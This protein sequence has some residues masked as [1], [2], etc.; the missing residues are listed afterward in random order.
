MTATFRFAPSPNGRLHLG[1]ALSALLNQDMA[2]ALGGRV[3]LRI[4]DIDTARCTPELVTAMLEDLD[5]IG[6]AAEPP[7]RR[8]SEHFADYD[9]ALTR[10][11]SM[12]LVYDAFLTRTEIRQ[13]VALREASGTPWPRDPDGAPLYPGDAALLT[14]D[15]IEARRRGGEPFAVRLDMRRALQM[16]G[17]SLSWQETGCGPAGETGEVPADPAAWGDVI[18]ARK[19]TPTSYHLSV[20]IDDALQGVSHVVR[21]QDLFHATAVHRLL[22]TLLQLPVPVYHHHRLIA[23]ADGRKLS[24]SA[25]DTGLAELR[26][27]GWTAADVRA[28]I[29]LGKNSS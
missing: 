25:G 14:A 28:R 24:K 23:D 5:W 13:A 11:K 27:A 26:A 29:G 20:V 17:P 1:H 19:D 22:Q 9:A 4:E 8:Q 12:G 3:L 6:F 21:G 18:L 10:L 15:Q 16:A 7:H 2:R